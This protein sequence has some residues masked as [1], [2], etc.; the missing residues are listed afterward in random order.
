VWVSRSQIAEIELTDE[1]TESFS[2]DTR[3]YNFLREHG[4]NDVVN[5][6]F[7]TRMSEDTHPQGITGALAALP[8]ADKFCFRV[9]VQEWKW[10][11]LRQGRNKTENEVYY[12]AAHEVGHLLGLTHASA[13]GRPKNLMNPVLR[14]M[15]RIEG[16]NWTMSS[17]T[18]SGMPSW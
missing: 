12:T 14:K 15:R 4:Q 10:P 18:L 1:L 2:S 7:I 16:R 5:L 9:V 6:I 17:S 11:G 13:R 8:V 3:T